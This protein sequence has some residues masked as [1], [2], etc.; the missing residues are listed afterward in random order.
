VIR[1]LW[2]TIEGKR[3]CYGWV[4]TL[5]SS[6]RAQFIAGMSGGRGFG[7][8]RAAVVEYMGYWCGGFVTYYSGKFSGDERMANASHGD[9]L[10]VP[11]HV[12]HGRE[13]T[14]SGELIR[15]SRGLLSTMARVK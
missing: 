15:T 9:A 14:V 13:A 2:W 8:R 12:A 5:Q 3:G 11:R 1:G 6:R 4:I 7:R 10:H